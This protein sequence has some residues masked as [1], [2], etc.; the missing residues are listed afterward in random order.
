ML[1]H[2]ISFKLCLFAKKYLVEYIILIKK[3]IFTYFENYLQI[4]QCHILLA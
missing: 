2:S 1:L 4:W 3:N